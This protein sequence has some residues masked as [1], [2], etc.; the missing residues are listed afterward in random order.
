MITCHTWGK[1]AVLV[2]ATNHSLIASAQEERSKEV[3]KKTCKKEATSSAEKEYDRLK[4]D[5]FN[6]ISHELRT[7]INVVLG[8]IQ[9][10]DRMGDD[11]FLEN[12]RHKFK[13]YNRIMKQNCYRLLRLVNN[14]IDVTKMDSGN[15]SLSPANHNVVKF[16]EDIANY[17]LKYAE[18]KGLSLVFHKDENEIITAFDG[19]KITRVILNLISNAIKF[20]PKNG[21]I[22]LSVRRDESKVYISVKDSGIG[23]PPEKFN[24]IFERFSQVDNTLTRNYEGSGIG[25]SLCSSIVRLHGGLIRV[26]S[27]PEKGS[28]FVIELPLHQIEPDSSPL[29]LGTELNLSL[30]E[31][32]KIEL[33]ELA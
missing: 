14:L 10:F 18:S 5:F 31:K 16:I 9:L 28:E 8:S 21:R 1:G 33:S 6:N 4:N 11:L 23:I 25:L 13:T 22:R 19:D 24:N 32:V 7:P 12:N 15:I 27:K 26:I 20:T 30:N 3:Q 2:K 17:S 29:N